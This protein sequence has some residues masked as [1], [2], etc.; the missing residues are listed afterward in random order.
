MSD[1]LPTD[2]HESSVGENVEIWRDKSSF[3]LR[4]LYSG[5]R[6]VKKNPP[7]AGYFQWEVD[8]VIL[9]DT[10]RSPHNYLQLSI[11]LPPSLPASGV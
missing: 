7:A 3:S 4:K 8:K 11:C 5:I 1:I 2:Q 10:D 9:F 6:N